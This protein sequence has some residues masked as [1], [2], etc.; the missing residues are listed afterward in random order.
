MNKHRKETMNSVHF[1]KLGENRYLI[2][3]SE[4]YP[5]N[6]CEEDEAIISEEHL[7]W[8]LTFKDNEIRASEQD[9]DNLATEVYYGDDN[10]MTS[11]GLIEE[12]FTDDVETELWLEQVLAPMGEKAIRRAKL[13]YLDRCT[14]YAIGKMEN[15]SH[16]MIGKSLAKIEKRLLKALK[17]DGLINN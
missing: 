6:C 12:A 4:F 2:R 9:D 5:D 16:N 1:E 3:V 11:L 13:F 10:F 15:V 7:D 8:L 14:K 17:D